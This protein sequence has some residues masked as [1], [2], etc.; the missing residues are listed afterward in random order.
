VTLP[1]GMDSMMA[2]AMAGRGAP[3][4]VDRA[5]E[6]RYAQWEAGDGWVIELS[7]RAAARDTGTAVGPF[8]VTFG[9]RYT[10]Q[11]TASVPLPYGTPGL[12]PP[13]V[14][15]TGPTWWSTPGLGSA[16]G[17]A[18]PY[19]FTGQATFDSDATSAD[20]CPINAKTRTVI[21]ARSTGQ[22]SVRN[23][24]TNVTFMGFGAIFQTSQDLTT[25]TV[26]TGASGTMTETRSTRTM[27]MDCGAPTDKTEQSTSDVSWTLQF[28]AASVPLPASPRTMTGSVTMPV[29]LQI[30]S[31]NGE[32]PADVTWTLRQIP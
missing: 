24:A 12:P 26:R 4:D 31:F 32:I 25:F 29:R 16:K 13:L 7:I 1:P 18:V 21:N 19:T 28:E 2:A 11:A 15:G 3:R 30:G 23:E 20:Q 22:G 27:T 6:A 8:Q 9:S 10:L 5:T 14:G 17:L